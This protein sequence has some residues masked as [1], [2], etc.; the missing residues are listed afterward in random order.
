MS[1]FLKKTVWAPDTREHLRHI[2]LIGISHYL[3]LCSMWHT[4]CLQWIPDSFC[5]LIQLTTVIENNPIKEGK[6]LFPMKIPKSTWHKVK[7][8]IEEEK[9]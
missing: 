8:N 5:K 4:V 9:G 3:Q 6:K 7:P 1:S 2:P